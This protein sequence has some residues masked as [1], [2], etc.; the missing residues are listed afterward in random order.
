MRK[1]RVATAFTGVAAG[2]A[3]FAPAAKANTSVPYPYKIWVN[4]SPVISQVQVCG[5][6]DVSN[7]K[8]TCTAKHGN[9]CFSVSGEPHACG[10]YQ[11]SNWQTG[12]T[13]VWMW[14]PTNGGIEEFGHT[15]NT[16]GSYHG[17]FRTGGVSLSA[18]NHTSLGASNAEC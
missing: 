11:G 8:W 18:G 9:P 14:T 5:Y 2:V 15:C 6:K 10:L 1:M 16:F 13:N 7:G 4:T 3:A 17:V 12:K